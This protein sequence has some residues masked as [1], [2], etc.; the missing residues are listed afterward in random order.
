MSATALQRVVVRMLFDPA[1]CQRVYA[2]PASA[3]SDVALTPEERQW[4]V[5]SDP[6]AYGVDVHRRSRALTGLLEEYPVAAALAVRCAQG[7]Q[8]L[9]GF[10]AS[11]VFH[12]CIQQRGSMADA[13]GVYVGSEA[14][15]EQPLI[16]C[17]AEVERSIARVRRAPVLSDGQGETLT[18]D[19]CLCLAPWVALLSLPD[20]VLPCYGQWRTHLAQH[21]ASLLDAVLDTRYPLPAAPPLETGETEWILVVNTSEA[22]GPSLEP[23]SPELGALLAAA[24]QNIVCHD[25]CALAVRLGA[26][27]PEAFDVIHGLCADRLLIQ[28]R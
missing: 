26:E 4:L 22:D 6:R 7:V 2:D 9:Y 24:Q 18:Q 3:L 27:P 15:A 5:A 10:F 20:T 14:F 8:R 1:F 16:A 23:T 17:L 13:F 28:C 12:Q 21:S 11:V 25:L 19:A